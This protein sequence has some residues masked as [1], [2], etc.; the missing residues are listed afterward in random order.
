MTSA[1]SPQY[2]GAVVQRVEAIYPVAVSKSTTGAGLSSG[3]TKTGLTLTLPSGSTPVDKVLVEP[4]TPTDNLAGF[5]GDFSFTD[6]SNLSASW[7]ST[8]KTV[9]PF[10]NPLPDGAANTI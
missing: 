9:D 2:N 5:A 3:D 1:D 7:T 4:S 10:G 8:R 6:N